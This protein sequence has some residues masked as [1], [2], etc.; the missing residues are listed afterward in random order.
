MYGQKQKKKLSENYFFSILAENREKYYTSDF[1]HQ[2]FYLKII[3][4]FYIEYIFDLYF[5]LISANGRPAFCV[6][7]LKQHIMWA[8]GRRF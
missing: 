8:Q 3:F 2:R 4:S 1:E 6:L 7:S 5:L